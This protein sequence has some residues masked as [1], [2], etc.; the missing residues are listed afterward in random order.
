MLQ[1]REP[2]QRSGSPRPHYR[3]SY[4]AT[5]R[6]TPVHASR[7]KSA[8]P[9][10]ALAPL[11]RGTRPPDWLTATLTPTHWLNFSQNPKSID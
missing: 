9:P 6:V 11:C 8:K 7:F 10:N 2:R 4:V 5:L 3:R 1:R